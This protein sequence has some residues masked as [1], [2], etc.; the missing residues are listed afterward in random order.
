[1]LE[2]TPD[3]CRRCDSSLVERRVPIALPTEPGWWLPL[4]VWVFGGLILGIGGVAMSLASA[5]TGDWAKLGA[6]LPITALALGCIGHGMRFGFERTFRFDSKNNRHVQLYVYTLGDRLLR[7]HRRE[8]QRLALRS[9]LSGLTRRPAR[10]ITLVRAQSIV[11]RINQR[12]VLDVWGKYIGPWKSKALNA[13]RFNLFVGLLRLVGD[14]NAEVWRCSVS[15]LR[16]SNHLAK[17]SARALRSELC[18]VKRNYPP[19]LGFEKVWWHCLPAKLDAGVMLR[20][21]SEIIAEHFDDVKGIA[22]MNKREASELSEM[23]AA[24]Y[25]EE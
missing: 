3:R 11:W 17:P 2:T 12:D 16:W 24:A 25:A 5:A 20:H 22:A 4:L 15:D 18:V 1:L 19:A 21:A 14:G 10:F 8:R 9:Q 7:T 6:A 13:T 23:L